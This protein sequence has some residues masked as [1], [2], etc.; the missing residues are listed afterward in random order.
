MCNKRNFKNTPYNRVKEIKIFPPLFVLCNDISVY[1]LL[2]L[3]LL[4]EMLHARCY[5]GNYRKKEIFSIKI[6]WF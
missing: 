6:L 4:T 1:K 2:S 5:I 3:N